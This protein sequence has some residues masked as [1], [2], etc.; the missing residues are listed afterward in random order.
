MRDVTD[1]AK[2][3]LVRDI[4]LDG[5]YIRAGTLISLPMVALRMAFQD[6]NSPSFLNT[7]HTKVAGKKRGPKPK[8]KEV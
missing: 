8:V 2:L 1:D 6:D 3:T 4:I 7:T 5:K